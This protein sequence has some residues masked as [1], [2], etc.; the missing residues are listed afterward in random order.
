MLNLN[1]FKRLLDI[2][3]KQVLKN[4]LLNEDKEFID[5]YIKKEIYIYYKSSFKINISRE[6]STLPLNLRLYLCNVLLKLEKERKF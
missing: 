3:I 2:E 1:N 6:I 4:T 5:G